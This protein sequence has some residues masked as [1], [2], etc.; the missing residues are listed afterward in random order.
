MNTQVKILIDSIVSGDITEIT[1]IF[2]SILME[3]I[4]EKININKKIVA[5]N[6][7]KNKLKT[8]PE[9]LDH[10]KYF[11]PNNKKVRPEH[12]FVDTKMQNKLQSIFGVK[13]DHTKNIKNKINEDEEDLPLNH[14]ERIA[15]EPQKNH[16]KRLI[17]HGQTNEIQNFI[18]SVI[19]RE[20]IQ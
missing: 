4:A 12:I 3:K 18:K 1:N 6:I 9:N 8:E 5:S 14:F 16:L 2:N 17:Q 7:T 19:N 13:H 10:Q 11:N 15:T 20:A